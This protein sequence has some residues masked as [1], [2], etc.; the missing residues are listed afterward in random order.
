MVNERPLHGYEVNKL[1]DQ[2]N[3]RKWADI[4]FSSIYYVLEKLE[5][6]GLLSSADARGKEKKLYEITSDGRKLLK[7]EAVLLLSERKPA[8]TPLMTGLVASDFID[9]TDLLKALTMRKETLLTD[10][11]ALRSAQAHARGAPQSAQRL[12]SLSETLL[13]AELTWIDKEIER[14]KNQ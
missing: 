14:I 2:R 11:G 9:K 12:F 3:I 4:G 7:T 8:N 13:V 6:R 1:F 5:S 10:L